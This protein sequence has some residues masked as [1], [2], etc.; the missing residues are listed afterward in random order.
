MSEILITMLSAL[1]GTLGFSLLFGMRPKHLPWALIGGGVACGVYVLT[2][3][4]GPFLCNAI[5][6]LVL[7]LYCELVARVQ[8]APV[9][10]FF[11]A[12]VV[13]LVPGSGLYYTIASLLQQ[14]YAAAWEFGGRTLA[15][16][17]GIVAGVLVGSVAVY[18]LCKS[19]H[20]HKH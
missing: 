18:G 4:L 1:M 6:S 8:K 9:V 10:C 2:V 12:S 11:A 3:S 7:M 15:I 16:C 14:Q 17:L 20:L 5:A 19:F 13:V